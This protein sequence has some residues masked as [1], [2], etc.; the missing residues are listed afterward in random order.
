M[1]NLTNPVTISPDEIKP[2]MVFAVTVTCHIDGLG[3]P[4]LYRCPYPNAQTV[5]GI[6]QGNQI[7][8]K[9]EIINSLFPVVN[10]RNRD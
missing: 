5:D 3:H 6:P 10:W 7:E 4:R 1:S 2:G 8:A 9:D